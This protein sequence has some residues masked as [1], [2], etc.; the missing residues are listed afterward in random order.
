MSYFSLTNV[1][2]IV[3]TLSFRL[4]SGPSLTMALAAWATVALG[5]P[6]LNS[7]PS[8]NPNSQP[9]QMDNGNPAR[10][11]KSV[12]AGPIL[13]AIDWKRRVGGEVPGIAC[14]RA[15]RAILGATFY[16]YVW[17]NELYV[18]TY[19]ADGNLSWRRKVTPFDWG[20]GQGVKSGP[21]L[22][23]TGNALMNSG[24]G[25]VIKLDGAG[26]LLTT[27]LVRT[28][29]A[30]DSSPAWNL[31]GTYV[32]YH[33]TVLRKYASD[34]SVIWSTSAASQTDPA[35]AANG[36]VA[37]GGVRTN[38]PHGSVDVSYF[39]A[40]GSLRWRKTS[41]RGTRTQVCFGPDGT[42]YTTVGGV[43][44]F[45][46]D[47]S[48]RWNQAGGGWGVCLDNLGKA[49]VPVGNRIQA[50][51]RNTGAPI[52]TATLP[53]PGGIVEGLTIDGANR[54]YL[55]TSDGFVYCLGTDGQV[56]W[57]LSI[58]GSATCQPAIGA[59]RTLYVA[60][61]YSFDD[62]ALIRIKEATQ[63]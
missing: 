46:P 11:G 52:Y 26:N 9:W 45:N 3:V 55:S 25:E 34:G 40:D 16:S 47:G 12:Y 27:V 37:L 54:V 7:T 44:A 50:Y 30:N 42:V 59:N 60:T 58:G 62:H 36:D 8:L 22:D 5:Q 21:A 61:T 2:P 48:V 41:T 53:T 39:N 17:S 57:S 13:G 14:D 15:G 19:R 29:A 10:T 63:Q 28:D 31:D 38:E 49:L 56:L 23:R 1:T 51:D 32:H 6:S 18:Q 4:V 33:A 35:V 20:A 24:N 43:T